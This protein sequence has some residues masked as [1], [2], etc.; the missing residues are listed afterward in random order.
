[1][2]VDNAI[3][4]ALDVTSDKVAACQLVKQAAKR[5]LSDL[6][7]A[8]Q[9]D[10]KWEYRRDLAERVMRWCQLL[11]NIK[12]PLAG[13]MLK[14]MPWQTF[15]IA[16]L[17]GF[18]E[19][20]TTTRRFRQGIV[21]IP[22][23]NGKTTFAAPLM[24]YASFA[25]NEGGAEAYAAAVSRDQSKLL[26]DSAKQMILKTP[27][28]A[29]A[30]GITVAAHSI[31]QVRSGSKC[32][33]V[34]SDAKSLEGLSVHFAC[35]DEIA[36]HLS[37]SVY[38]VMLTACGKRKH[39]LLLS[40]STATGN[41]HGIGRTLWDY[42][43][44]VLNGDQDD[45]R[46][47]ALIYTVDDGDD[48]WDEATWVKANPSWGVSVQPDAIRAIMRQARNNPAQEAA[49]MTRHLNVWVGADEALFSTRAWRACADP[50][51]RL[52][53]FEGE[54]CEL[55]VDLANKVDLAA[56]SIVFPSFDGDK[57]L[58][59]VFGRHYI[60]ESAVLEARNALY[61]IWARDGHLTITAGNE[62][63]FSVIESDIIALCR[64]FRVRSV[65]FDPWQSAMLAQRLMSDNINCVEVQQNVKNMSEPTKELQAAMVA[66]RIRHTGD[67]VLEWAIG[68][69]VG[70]VDIN[71]NVK[72]NKSRDDAQK[73]DPAIA[74]IMALARCVTNESQ[75]SV[76]ETRGMLVLGEA[77]YSSL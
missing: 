26:W 45:D 51:L 37:S 32:I 8:E 23:G 4:Y 29:Q 13:Q 59:A 70:H 41:N 74:L 21:F 47:F 22:R 33:A 49:A 7:A 31:Y 44:R 14:L 30:L 62:T 20:G 24:L 68:N 63:D 65:A 10:S 6:Q 48:P 76:Y 56:L 77:P 50:T 36:S 67:P 60:N 54:E 72:P 58:Y 53:D 61:P 55:A 42:G 39:P 73:I 17:F 69:V 46:L 27:E 19:R 40:I 3:Q 38:D 43:A 25:D 28:L 57:S 9:P 15:T 34:S 52:E 5:F 64:R 16:N 11:P 35:C 66:N 71:S 75:P 18:V 12:G 2:S 1:M